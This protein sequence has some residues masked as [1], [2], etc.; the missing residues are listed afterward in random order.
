MRRVPRLMR[1]S[2]LL[3]PQ[4]EPQPVGAR[5]HDNTIL[6]ERPNQMWGI[7]ATVGFTL[8]EGPVTIFAM[9]DHATAECLGMHVARRG[10]R[11]E[12]LEPVR[13]AVHEQFGGIAEAIAC[14]VSP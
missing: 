2:H 1:D 7:D 3:A 5:H 6:A 11:F 4:R 10:T 13:R 8:A 14:G 9:V 12:A